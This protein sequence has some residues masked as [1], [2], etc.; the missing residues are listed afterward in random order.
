MIP[1]TM[2]AVLLTGFG[3]LDRLDYRTDVPVPRPGRGEVLVQVGACGM[4]NTDINLRTRWYDRAVDA[5][6]TEDFGSTGAAKPAGADDAATVASWGEGTV[7]FPLIQ[8]AAVAGRIVASGEG[9][10]A[11]RVGERVLVDP[12]ARDPSR[13]LRAQLVSYMG[14]DRNGGF[15]EYVALP[16]ACA[17]AIH[18]TL[19]DAELAT[20]PCSYDTAEEMLERARLGAG[21]CVVV[22]G[23]AGGVGSAAIQLA[24]LRG[25][26]VIAVAGADKEARIRGLGAQQFVSRD[27][28]DP[29]AAVRALAGTGGVQV[30]ADV[31]GG[32]MYGALLKMLDR[33]GRYVSA[34][35]IA[36]PVQPMD[37]RDLI[38]KDLEMHGITCP[39]AATFGRVV[40]Y[41][42][43]GRL[44]ALVERTYPLEQLRDAQAEMVKRRHFGKFVVVPRP[45]APQN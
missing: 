37:L 18:S 3:G 17:H 34:G 12:S 2:K 40:A 9:V 6:L 44:R 20:F 27:T 35:A 42:N 13:P 1:T 32:P 21:E 33:G 43:A 30:V 23:A 16:A 19:D 38:Y 15:A 22:T 45:A 36:G 4:N 26:K 25:A 5:A 31:V 28:P 8:G 14:G 41:L 10:P 24:L 11:S 29:L 39:T 7:P